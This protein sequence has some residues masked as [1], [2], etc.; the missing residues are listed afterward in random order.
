MFTLDTL[1]KNGVIRVYATCERV[2]PESAS[3]GVAA[4]SGW[5]TSLDS[6]MF[7]ESRNDVAP[8]FECNTEE[9]DEEAE[10]ELIS[11]LNS[12]GSNYSDDGSTIYGQERDEDYATG[13][14]YGY[15]LHAHVKHF[16]HHLGETAR[17][18]WVETNL[19]I[20]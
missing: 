3:E 7:Y 15:A 20:I 1:P 11:L 13:D 6:R 5:V 12:L 14:E 18:G 19:A 4:E 17:G 8:V 16:E 10:N 2:T 9:F